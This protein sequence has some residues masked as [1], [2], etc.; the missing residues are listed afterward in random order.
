MTWAAL[1][2]LPC[3]AAFALSPAD[4]EIQVNSTAAGNQS[5]PAVC[6]QEN[7]GY[8]VVWES[9]GQDSSGLGVFGRLLDVRG[10]V[11]GGE[12]QVNQ[13]TSGNQQLPDVACG[14]GGS[15]TVVWESEKQDGDGYGIFARRFDREGSAA[16]DELAVN[17]L[18]ED[19]QLAPRICTGVDG[20]SLVVWQ[21]FGQDGDGEGVYGRRFDADGASPGSEF[22]VSRRTAENQ[23]RPALACLAGGGQ[24]V[25][26]Q[27]RG[28]DGDGE[29]I[30]A[31]LYD[32]SGAASGGEFQVNERG[33]DN[34][35]AP[36][37]AAVGDGF[38]VAWESSE[39]PDGHHLYARRF[40]AG[41]SP[42][43]GDF[44]V[45]ADDF[46][47]SEAPVISGDGAG[48][49]IVAWSGGSGFEYDVLARRYHSDGEPRGTDLQL[50]SSVGGNQGALSFVGRGVA[51]AGNAEAEIVVWQSTALD[52]NSE[53]GSGSGVFARSF[54]PCPG[55]CVPD[56]TVRVAELVQGVNIALDLLP[57]SACTPFD[58]DGDGLVSVGELVAAVG[59]A[60]RG[61]SG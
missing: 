48:N 3:G 46:A 58:T 38:L 51:I 59:A 9:A 36:S 11:L 22:R 55:D 25:V 20:S 6:R 17:V 60:L 15:F 35:R 24:V 4:P 54:R 27:S 18:T 2:L 1:A 45:N 23:Q 47:R 40:A 52:G 14:P 43:G 61:C 37:V 28:Q 34:Q 21:S 8:V 16:G 50:S 33:E 32:A 49:S 41:G 13:H 57:L 10:A 39:Y 7:G 31:Q 44:R 12:F 42:L 30:F 5:Y 53:D 19:N 29:G 56:G 26:W